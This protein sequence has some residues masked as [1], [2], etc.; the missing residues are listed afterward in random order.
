MKSTYKFLLL[1]GLISFMVAGCTKDFE[2]TNTDPNKAIKVPTYSLLTNVQ[3][4]FS[5]NMFDSWWGGRQSMLWAQYWSQNN[6]TD[7]DRYSIRQNVN[8]N[9]W[10]NFYLIT[11]DLNEII[12]INNDPEQKVKASA[13]C[14]NA[15]QIATAMIMKAWI[16]QHLTDLYGN[17]PYFTAW[18]GADDVFLTTYDNQELIYRDVV[19]QL[20][21]AVALIDGDGGAGWSQGDIIYGG[22]MAKWR[23][24]ANSLKLRMAMRAKKVDITLGTNWAN[25]AIASG[26]MESNEDNATFK[27]LGAAPNNA[28]MWGAYNV[29]NRSDHSVTMQFI[30]LLKGNPVGGAEKPNPFAGL[31]DPRL[32][33]FAQ[34]VVDTTVL[35]PGYQGIPYGMDDSETKVIGD[36]GASR[37]GKAILASDFAV[38]YMNYSEVA[39][40]K[41][42]LNGWSQAEYE[43]GV[44][45]SMDYWGVSQAD[46]DT[47]LVH[48]PAATE[49]TVLTQKY[50]ALY[51]QGYEAWSEYRRT[52]YP[53]TLVHPGEVTW[54]KADGSTVVFETIFGEDIPRRMTWPQE[55]Q[56]LNRTNYEAAVSAFGQADAFE[57]RVW[58]DKL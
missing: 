2:E 43:E 54:K 26:V 37:P 30:D 22:N 18:Q 9:Y 46:K 36:A 56:T 47:F 12:R 25:E 51:T 32:P 57:S 34:P 15:N 35:G 4:Q 1:L 14:S 31:F 17:I 28:P 38:I 20:D 13:Y 8:S 21:A 24:F 19:A 29:D 44:S 53:K 27:F 10:R 6:Y 41:S 33:I 52:G 45:A 23:K 5:Y 11:T 49:E 16:V 48:M 42:E 58:W 7:E 50:I 55:E 39:F 3:F 40:I